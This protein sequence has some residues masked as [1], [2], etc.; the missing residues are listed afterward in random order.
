LI[1][2][3][4]LPVNTHIQALYGRESKLNQGQAVDTEGKELKRGC[5]LLDMGTTGDG[6]VSSKM[7]IFLKNYFRLTI[8]QAE[9]KPYPKHPLSDM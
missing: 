8:Q 4:E 7:E 9:N 2:T 6:C 5:E 1:S 3:F